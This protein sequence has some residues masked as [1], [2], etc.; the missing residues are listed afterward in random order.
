MGSAFSLRAFLLDADTP[1]SAAATL[2][3]LKPKDERDPLPADSA[4][5]NS[6]QWPESLRVLAQW[7]LPGPL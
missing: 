1:D 4:N 3:A 6:S 2:R 5:V 7:Q